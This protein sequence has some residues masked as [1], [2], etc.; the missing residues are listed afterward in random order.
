M[1]FVNFFLAEIIGIL[2]GLVAISLIAIGGF[3]G[4]SN[5]YPKGDLLSTIM[6]LGAGLL[7]SLFVCGILALFISIRS[8]LV[9]IND[10]LKLNEKRK[11][12]E[13]FEKRDHSRG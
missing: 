13:F 6:G 9:E 10:L 4:Y 8:E 7:V 12:M 11:E 1:K 5:G 3:Y 2:N